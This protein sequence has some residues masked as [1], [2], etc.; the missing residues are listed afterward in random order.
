M[1]EL[2]LPDQHP[3]YSQIYAMQCEISSI[4]ACLIEK[5]IVTMH[6]NENY[7]PSPLFPVRDVVIIPGLLPIFL[8]GYEKKSGNGLGTR[9]STVKG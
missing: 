5:K 6:L 7:K 4:M 9:L 1:S 2:G 8:H 3:R